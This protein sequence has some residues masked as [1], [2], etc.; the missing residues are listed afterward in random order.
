M[1]QKMEMKFNLQYNFNWIQFNVTHGS[2]KNGDIRNL[3]TYLIN[4]VI[5]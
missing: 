1:K 4:D 2:L 5:L 3:I